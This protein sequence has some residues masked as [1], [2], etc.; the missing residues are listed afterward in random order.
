VYFHVWNHKVRIS[1][2]SEQ[3]RQVD[4]FK[5]LGSVISADRYCGTGTNEPSSESE[6]IFNRRIAFIYLFIYLFIYSSIHFK[7]VQ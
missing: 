2:D 3:V 4:Q 7:M 1:T 5:Y 6:A